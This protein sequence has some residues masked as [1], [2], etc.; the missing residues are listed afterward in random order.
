MQ[1]PNSIHPV[2]NIG[3]IMNLADGCKC[4]ALPFSL[5]NF[6]H[7]SRPSLS[8]VVGNNS[9][10]IGCH[11]DGCIPSCL[12]YPIQVSFKLLILV[13]LALDDRL[14]YRHAYLNWDNGL[15][16]ISESKGSGSR[17]VSFGKPTRLRA[18]CLPTFL[19]LLLVF[20]VA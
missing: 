16:P 19:W 2:D 6:Q 12:V 15:H 20:S 17:Q 14:G 3:G 13:S 9:L 7:R 18:V 10:L 5:G 4:N 8:V 1:W 11:L